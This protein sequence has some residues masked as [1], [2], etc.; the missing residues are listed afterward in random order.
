MEKVRYSEANNLRVPCDYTAADGTIKT[1][2]RKLR[3][4]D[5]LQFFK[6]GGKYGTSAI[7]ADFYA[8]G[9]IGDTYIIIRSRAGAREDAKLGYGPAKRRV[10]AICQYCEAYVCPGH[11]DQHQRGRDCASRQGRM[12]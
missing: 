4:P 2:Q 3:S 8:F 9:A 1:Y 10:V 7:P 11:L 6:I 12:R 5:I